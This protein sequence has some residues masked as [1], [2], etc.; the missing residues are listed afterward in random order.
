MNR[1]KIVLFLLLILF[2]ISESEDVLNYS[3]SLGFIFDTNISRNITE[4]NRA[5]IIPELDFTFNSPNGIPLFLNGK[6]AFD[7]YL[8]ERDF[9]DNSPFVVLGLG[10]KKH[11]KKLAFTSQV[12]GEYYMGFGFE[13]DSDNESW[14]AVERAAFVETELAYKKKKRIF[15]LNIKGGIED[16]G[17]DENGLKNDKT[18]YVFESMPSFNYKFKKKK[19]K[20]VRVKNVGI[21]FRYEL[22]DAFFREDDF[23]RFSIPV[24]LQMKIYKFNIES[25]V[26]VSKKLYQNER[27]N[28]LT[29]NIVSP[30]YNRLSL[31]ADISVP[32]VSHLSVNVGGKLR[33]RDSNWASFNYNRHT[34]HLFL[35]W[36]HKLER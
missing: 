12:F 27:I 23:N 35:T 21:A 25:E 5:Y 20:K 16:Y 9:D 11:K 2:T 19:G 18:G 14:K 10:I 33:F 6:L 26:E 31:G 1:F 3:A 15:S 28:E 22:K 32:L 24:K 7:H 4:S 30:Y 29:N 13:T 34:C 8:K 17:K 36:K